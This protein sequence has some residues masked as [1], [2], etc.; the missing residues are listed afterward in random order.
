ML[1]GRI[2]SW[3]LMM[4]VFCWFVRLL[5][6]PRRRSCSCSRA[7][8]NVISQ[9]KCQFDVAFSPSVAEKARGRASFLPRLLQQQAKGPM[10]VV[11]GGAYYQDD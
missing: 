8:A 9:K 5:H 11:D 1:L 4:E 7:T 3:L 2:V 10:V 6:R